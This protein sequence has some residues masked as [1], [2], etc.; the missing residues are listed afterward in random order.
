VLVEVSAVTPWA[1][2]AIL[3][4]LGIITVAVVRTRTPVPPRD[5]DP[6]F[7]IGIV[8]AG[9]GGALIAATGTQ[10]VPIAIVGILLIAVGA[11]RSR[12]REGRE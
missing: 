11:R 8:M 6:L 3:A 2:L 5:P 1:V 4:L 12:S 7:V 9:T 10:M